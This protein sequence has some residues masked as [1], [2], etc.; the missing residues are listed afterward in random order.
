MSSTTGKKRARPQ[1][2]AQAE[3]EA[4]LAASDSEAEAHEDQNQAQGQA[5]V[6]PGKKLGAAPPQGGGAKDA[7]RAMIHEEDTGAFSYDVYED[8]MFNVT[9]VVYHPASGEEDVVFER[10][11]KEDDDDDWVLWRLMEKGR[12]AMKVNAEML[13]DLRKV[14]GTVETYRDEPPPPLVVNNRGKIIARADTDNREHTM[15]ARVHWK[16]KKLPDEVTEKIEGKF[17]LEID[18]LIADKHGNEYRPKDEDTGSMCA[19][20]GFPHAVA[21]TKEKGRGKSQATME[22][23]VAACN[24]VKLTV[25]LKK[26]DKHNNVVPASEAELIH[27]IASQRSVSQMQGN[28][29]YEQ[30]MVLYVALE[31]ADTDDT[32]ARVP[33][34]SFVQEPVLGAMFTPAES[35]PYKGGFYEFP[36][37]KGVAPVEFRIAKGVTTSA[38]KKP[39]KG[40]QFRFVVK[41]LNPFLCGL[42]GFTART[43]G[44]CL[45]GV[46][47]NDVKSQERYV[48]TAEGIVESLY[49]DHPEYDK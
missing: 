41:A 38:L 3:V 33:P 5:A 47:H 12:L 18:E 31:F 39:H 21:Y 28:L 35:A 4:S 34:A 6:Q 42:E 2:P 11:K 7:L 48:Q 29:D 15:P 26:Y 30:D 36:M 46:L 8:E 14:A 49:S 22:Y 24:K 20:S 13:E 16:L 25:R 44:F 37:I 40:R 1:G 32:F 43:R 45:K 17:F 10:P 9:K 19:T 27:M 23:I